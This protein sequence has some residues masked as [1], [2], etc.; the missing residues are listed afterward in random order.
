MNTTPLIQQPAWKALAA[1]HQEVALLKLR[2]LF[3]E[4][5]NVTARNNNLP[6]AQLFQPRPRVATAGS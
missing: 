5:G 1:H 3:A 2:D 6:G 4:F